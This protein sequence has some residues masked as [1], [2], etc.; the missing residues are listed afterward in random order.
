LAEI[1]V[2]GDV[3]VLADE[4]RVLVAGVEPTPA[5][6]SRA[7][8]LLLAL[9]AQRGQVVDKGTLIDRVWPGVVVE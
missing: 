5:L 3:H 7:F 8:D 6:G 2:L 9:I 1:H 4:R